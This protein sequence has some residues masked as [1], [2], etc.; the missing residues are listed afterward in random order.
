MCL[1]DLNHL[2]NSFASINVSEISI[3]IIMKFKISMRS[4]TRII[5]LEYLKFFH[6]LKKLIYFRFEDIK[7]G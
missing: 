3:D 4:E 7:M 5:H 1:K 6:N 2:K